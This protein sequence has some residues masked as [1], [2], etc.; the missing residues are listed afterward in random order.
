ML[1]LSLNKVPDKYT[2]TA[3]TNRRIQD[4]RES[5]KLQKNKQFIWFMLW[6]W[7]VLKEGKIILI[8]VTTLPH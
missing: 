3:V 8:R 1:N 7:K 4:V 2:F 6:K 5:L